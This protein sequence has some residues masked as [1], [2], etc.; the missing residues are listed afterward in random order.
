[1][2]EGRLRDRFGREASV[3]PEGWASDDAGLASTLNR[4][5]PVGDVAAGVGWVRA[6]WAAVEVLGAEV[7][8]EPEADST[9]GVIH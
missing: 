3:G 9:P 5:F 1:M 2:T 4:S 6:F 7:L 8:T